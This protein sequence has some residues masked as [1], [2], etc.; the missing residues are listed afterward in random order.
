[1]KP[2]LIYCRSGNR[3]GKAASAMQALGFKNIYNLDHGIKGWLAD[4]LPVK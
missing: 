4:G 1:D 2:V 3:S